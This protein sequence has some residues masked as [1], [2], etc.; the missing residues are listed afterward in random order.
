MKHSLEQEAYL[1]ILERT[2]HQG[3]RREK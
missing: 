1:W 3:T 2:N